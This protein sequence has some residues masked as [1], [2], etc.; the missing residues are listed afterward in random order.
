MLAIA[1]ERRRLSME[2]YEVD[3]LPPFMRSILIAEKPAIE[4]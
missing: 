3:G 4:P 1:E 2:Q